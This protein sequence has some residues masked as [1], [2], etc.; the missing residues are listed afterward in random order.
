MPIKWNV[1]IVDEIDS[2]QIPVLEA[3]KQGKDEGFAVRALKQNNGKGRFNRKWEGDDEGN[4][5]LSFLLRPK[6]D[7]SVWGQ[8]S[9]VVAVA[10]AETVNEFSPDSKQFGL[11]WPN[12]LMVNNKKSAGILLEVENKSLI[13]GVGVNILNHPEG[14]SCLNDI[15]PNINS[16]DFLNKFLIKISDL[17][18]IWNVKGF[19]EIKKIWSNYC[20]MMGKL[21]NVS[22]V[23][24]DFQGTAVK[25]DEQG[26]L[27]VE[28][29]NGELKIVS[30]GDVYFSL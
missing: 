23:N 13:V 19:L 5:Y 16:D 27:H 29:L 3:A 1:D 4:I 22:I 25:L 12:D 24:D 11:K 15:I 10:L 18:D 7:I 20:I 21:V 14:K 26:N 8:L 2:T 17:Y 30:S 28:K 6:A 9:F